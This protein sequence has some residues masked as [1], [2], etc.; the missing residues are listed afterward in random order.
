MKIFDTHSHYYDERFCDEYDGS[1]DSLIDTL[2]DMFRIGN[3]LDN[4]LRRSSFS[5][6]DTT[7]SSLDNSLSG[8]SLSSSLLTLDKE[9]MF[10]R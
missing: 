9:K 2:L 10:H 1:V 8:G 6:L 5:H 7:L 3:L 4:L